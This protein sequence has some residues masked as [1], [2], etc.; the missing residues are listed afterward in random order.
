MLGTLNEHFWFLYGLFLL[1][2]W[3]AAGSAEH[4][5]NTSHGRSPFILTCNFISL[6]PQ[7]FICL[8][9]SVLHT[10]LCP[11]GC[12]RGCPKNFRGSL[13]KPFKRKKKMRNRG[14]FK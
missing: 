4:A 5:S 11:L 3:K 10:V 12:F 8:T 2:T 9:P 1:D 7:Q 13:N 14:L 6:R